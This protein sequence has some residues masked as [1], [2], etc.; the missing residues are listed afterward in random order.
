MAYSD[1]KYLNEN[2]N[3]DTFAWPGGY[4]IYYLAKDCEPIC[5]NC[6]NKEEFLIADTDDK[7]WY[8]VAQKINW[9]DTSLQCAHCNKQIE[10][11]YGDNGDNS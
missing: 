6:A 4:P 3:R 11:A 1:A 2:G 8:I 10:S 7:Q 9:E 5:A